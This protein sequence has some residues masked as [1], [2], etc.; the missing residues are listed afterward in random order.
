MTEEE[1]LSKKDDK[2]KKKN[3]F[4]NLDSRHWK[5]KL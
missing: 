4:L 1:L 5:M 2:E 3:C